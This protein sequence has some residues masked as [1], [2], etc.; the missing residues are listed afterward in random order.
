MKNE[1]YTKYL[2]PVGII[3]IFYI[4]GKKLLEKI[5]LSDSKNDVQ[6]ESNLS[7]KYLT[8]EP[9]LE[10]RK[11]T[12]FKVPVYAEDS[13]INAFVQRLW[14]SKGV[15]N[16]NE[17]EVYQIFRSAQSKLQVSCF[18]YYFNQI[19][20]RNLIEFLSSFLN[21]DEIARIAEI[22]NKKPNNIDG[23]FKI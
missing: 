3:I 18:A 10:F 6:L 9:F 11:K 22:I 23:F 1:E 7:N 20:G 14:N 15:F 2:L 8:P 17:D 4:F 5:G 19:K 12:G 21:S 16:D 13:L